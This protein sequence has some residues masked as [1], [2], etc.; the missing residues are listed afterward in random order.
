MKLLKKRLCPS[1]SRW[2]LS[3]SRKSSQFGFIQQ[4][5]TELLLQSPAMMS[6]VWVLTGWMVSNVG[7]EQKLFSAF[8]FCFIFTSSVCRI[9]NLLPKQFPS[10]EQWQQRSFCCLYIRTACE[11]REVLNESF[12]VNSFFLGRVCWQKSSFN[13]SA[14]APSL[15]LCHILPWIVIICLITI[16]GIHISW[17]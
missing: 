16:T 3:C 8:T 17:G 1:M 10:F 14:G 4:T 9:F 11:A 13:L 12:Y 15:W 7:G 5:L 2:C 6:S